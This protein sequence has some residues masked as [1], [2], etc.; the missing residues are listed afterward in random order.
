[1]C[2]ILLVED[3]PLNRAVF[4]ELLAGR[5][6]VMVAESAEIAQELLHETR[7]D[8]ILMDVQLPGMDGLTLTRILKADPSTAAIPV[9]VL[10]ALVL[11]SDVK[12]AYQAGCIDFISKPITDEPSVFLERVSR[13]LPP[14]EELANEGR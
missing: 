10:S 11:E 7:P 2:T 4:R 8:L 9:V 1:M 13:C 6:A 14:R 12:R 3:H 5:F